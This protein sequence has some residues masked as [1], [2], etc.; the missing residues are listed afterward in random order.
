LPSRGPPAV[1]VQGNIMHKIGS[2]QPRQDRVAAFMQTY[3]YSAADNSANP[4]FQLTMAEVRSFT[5]AE[6]L[7]HTVSYRMLC[8]GTFVPPFEN[9]TT[10]FCAFRTTSS[11]SKTFQKNS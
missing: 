1:I 11:A 3:F 8:Y 10:S 2:L 5:L 4:F 9:T 6:S 7:T